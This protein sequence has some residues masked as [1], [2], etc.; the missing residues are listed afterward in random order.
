MYF[1]VILNG[2]EFVQCW[3]ETAARANDDG[4][5]GA[6]FR[7]R[8]RHH[9]V[10]H[11][12]YRRLCSD[13][14]CGDQ[15]IFNDD[16]ETTWR[17]RVVQCRDECQS[18]G[19][20]SVVERGECI[21]HPSACLSKRLVPSDTRDNVVANIPVHRLAARV[22]CLGHVDDTA[23]E[24]TRRR[25]QHARSQH[26]TVGEDHRY[27]NTRLDG[28]RPA[29]HVA[30][31]VSHT[32]LLEPYRQCDFF[33]GLREG[34][35]SA[36]VHA[37]KMLVYVLGAAGALLLGANLWDVLQGLMYDTAPRHTLILRGLALCV[38]G[39]LLFWAVHSGAKV[40]NEVWQERLATTLG[41]TRMHRWWLIG[42][43]AASII[44]LLT[45]GAPGMGLYA[46]LDFIVN[47]LVARRASWAVQHGDTVWPTAIAYSLLAPWIAFASYLV[48]QR[49][50][51]LVRP[52][53][54]ATATTTATFFVML[55]VHIVYRFANR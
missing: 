45:I 2:A 42:A 46:V 17:M 24:R 26:N 14:A 41:F 19:D 29:S 13:S 43:A 20:V 39:G 36:G 6:A 55:V 52:L 5:A 35:V 49:L 27:Q 12:G 15:T 9:D 7:E 48:T 18:D 25:D 28:N 33:Y 37:M 8:K 50:W 53:L 30:Y 44:G 51:T 4:N 38:A 47:T 34:G 32:I 1:V 40:S 31:Y 54:V 16:V 11:R 3:R 22:A 23:I 10:D 21:S